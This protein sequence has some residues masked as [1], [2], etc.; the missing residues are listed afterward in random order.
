MPRVVT[1]SKPAPARAAQVI[2]REP[3]PAGLIEMESASGQLGR[4]DGGWGHLVMVA[5]G[6]RRSN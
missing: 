1:A 6:E 3:E 4:H 5:G 2:Q